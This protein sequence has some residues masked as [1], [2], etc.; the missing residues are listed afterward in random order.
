MPQLNPAPWFLIM[1]AAWMILTVIMMP[2]LINLH[3]MAG[4]TETHCPKTKPHWT[5]PWY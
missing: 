1:C 3:H 4:P 5:W 2:K